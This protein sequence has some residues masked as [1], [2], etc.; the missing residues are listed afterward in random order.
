M[1]RTLRS[2]SNLFNLL[3]KEREMKTKI[4]DLVMGYMQVELIEPAVK[5]TL[6]VLGSCGK[7]QSVK[8]VVLTSSMV[9]IAFK[10]PTQ[11]SNP[12][13]DETSFSDPIYAQEM[14]VTISL[15]QLN[16]LHISN[17]NRKPY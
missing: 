17:E 12:L 16:F 7:A 15:L 11:N 6:N 9:T 2:I 5:G 4:K 8:R 14:E 10:K 3:E 1:S 13:I